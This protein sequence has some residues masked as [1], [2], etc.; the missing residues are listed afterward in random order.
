VCSALDQCH[1]VGTCEPSTGQCSNPAKDDGTPCD[2]GQQCTPEET[3]VAGT[4]TPTTPAGDADADGV[5]DALDICGMYDPDQLDADGDGVGD[6]CECRAPAPGRCL[7]GGGNKRT[8]CL[9]E[10]N[11]SGPVALNRKG[12][13]VLGT[14]RCQDGDPACDRDG[15]KDGQ[16]TFGVTVCLGNADPRFPRCAEGDVSHFEVMSPDPV[17]AKSSMDKDN[18][19]TLERAVNLLGVEIV[20]NGR[21]VNEAVSTAAD[22]CTELLELRVPLGNGGKPASRVFKI[23]G[24][25]SDGRRDQDRLTLQCK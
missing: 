23:R 14:L 10:F 25:G 20:R 16:C 3:C 15:Q 9:V 22:S 6:A 12:T 13:M 7:P 11:T 17:R 2:D 8:D 21:I 4:C 19:L 18:A 1:T 24:D 5:C